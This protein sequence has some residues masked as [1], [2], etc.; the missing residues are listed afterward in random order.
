VLTTHLL[1]VSRSRKNRAIPLLPL[2]AF[3]SV[4]GYL[5]L[6]RFKGITVI[7]TWMFIILIVNCNL[8]FFNVTHFI[9][10]QTEYMSTAYLFINLNINFVNVSHFPWYN[11]TNLNYTFLHTTFTFSLYKVW[12]K[13]FSAVNVVPLRRN[14]SVTPNNRAQFEDAWYESN[15]VAVTGV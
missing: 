4:T 13:R 15:Y 14:F 5:Y 12:P 10:I 1:L 2:W 9:L 11:I 6:L 3:G 8:I 7:W